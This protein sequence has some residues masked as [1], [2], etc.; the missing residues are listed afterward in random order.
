[1]TAVAGHGGTYLKLVL[2]AC[3]WGGTFIAG[4]VAMGEMSAPVA[5]LWR[6]VI[7]TATLL[8]VLFAVERSMPRLAAAQ[9]ISVVLLGVTGVAAYNLCFMFGIQKVTAARGALIIALAPAATLLGGALFLH[10]PLN[11]FRVAGIIVALLGVAVELSGGNPLLL[12][13]GHLGIGEAAI[14]GCVLAW[15]AYTLIGKRLL[16][17]GLSPLATTTYAAL[18]GT[19]ML[20]A[21]SAAAGDLSLPHVSPKTWLSLAFMGVLGTAVAFVWFYDGVRTIGPARTAVFINLVPMV[22]ITLGVLLLGEALHWSMVVG[23]ALVVAGVFV[24][25]RA[26]AAA[27]PAPHAPAHV[28]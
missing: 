27:L 1:M 17:E 23:G 16:G 8:V 26:P 9:W 12:F 13:S 19:G 7:A 18:V 2:V 10:E 5:A 28:V 20:L 4:K 21:V 14:F 25:N 6:Y 22:A 15:A 11:R 3:I 24:I